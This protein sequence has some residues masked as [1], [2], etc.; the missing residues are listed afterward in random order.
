MGGNPPFCNKLFNRL[1][2]YLILEHN[3]RIWGK[4][5]F[6]GRGICDKNAKEKLDTNTFGEA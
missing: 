1:V 6:N 5:S 3:S 4:G 2:K